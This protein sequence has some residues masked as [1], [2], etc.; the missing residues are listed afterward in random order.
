MAQKKTQK[1]TRAAA[2]SATKVAKTAADTSEET[3]AKV[4]EEAKTAIEEQKQ[5]RDRAAAA[6]RKSADR[7]VGTVLEGYEGVS[8]AQKEAFDAYMVSGTRA[9]KGFEVLSREMIE[10]TQTSFAQNV[11]AAQNLMRVRSVREAVDLQSEYTRRNIDRLTKETAKLAELSVE[12]ATQ[13]LEPWQ[14]QVG[15]AAQKVLKQSA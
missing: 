15:R 7:S 12:V 11:E 3:V 6:A 4:A 10:F 9:A 14:A 1:T 5:I 13:V 2:K 8:A